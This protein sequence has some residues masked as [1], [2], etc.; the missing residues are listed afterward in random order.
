M[1]YIDI[2][3]GFFTPVRQTY[4]K[5]RSDEAPPNEV[6]TQKL[7]RIKDVSVQV[8]SLKDVLETLK[9]QPE[10]DT[11][12]ATLVF[13]SKGN[14]LASPSPE[15]AQIVQVLVS[16]IVPNYWPLIRDGHIDDRD[17]F[18]ACLRNISS[19]NAL[20]ARLKVLTQELKTSEKGIKRPDVSLGLDILL[21][22]LAGLLDGDQTLSAFWINAQQHVDG[23]MRQAVRQEFL[24]LFARSGRI[25]SIAAEA[26]VVMQKEQTQR[27]NRP[28]VADGLSYTNWIGRGISSWLRRE[29]GSDAEILCS[30][31]FVKALRLGYGGTVFHPASCSNQR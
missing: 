15:T 16:E 20:L 3:D 26:D 19:V 6:S 14:K 31:I 18:L 13:A 17:I 24:S 8:S 11:L 7:P 5:K 9:S 12:M 2:M 10:Y 21:Q 4:L 30:E 22:V 29:V 23:P 28:W 1:V 27:A 25:V